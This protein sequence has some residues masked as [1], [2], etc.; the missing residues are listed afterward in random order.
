[1]VTLVNTINTG[2]GPSSTH[3]MEINEQTGFLYRSGGGSNG[4]RIY[5]LKPD[6]TTPLYVSSWSTKYTHEVTLVN[7]TSGPLAGKE[8]AFAC[9][10][11][12]GGWANTGIDIL[13]VTNKANITAVTPRLLWPSGQYGHQCTLSADKT[14]LYLN[15]ELY[16]PNL[17]GTTINHVFDISNLGT[18]A[19]FFL[20]TFEPL[21]VKPEPAETDGFV[22]T[23][24]IEG[25]QPSE[26][27][28]G[29]Q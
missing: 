20:N 13:D 11:D 14:R 3:S 25:V 27:T 6:P 22:P 9:G 23:K 7:Y 19:P 18:S 4:L 5:D 10:G 21:I 12:N 2:P 24:L 29:V 17:G 1:M 26:L 16:V 8:I 28:F 15:D